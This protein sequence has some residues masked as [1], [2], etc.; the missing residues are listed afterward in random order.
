MP[1]LCLSVQCRYISDN[2]A[3]CLRRSLNLV[4]DFD[5]LHDVDPLLVA[6]VVDCRD[7]AVLVKPLRFSQL[8]KVAKNSQH[9]LG[10]GDSAPQVLE[11]FPRCSESHK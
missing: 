11:V 4:P 2:L 6:D 9:I 8:F 3:E 10:N 7:L 5:A 1:L